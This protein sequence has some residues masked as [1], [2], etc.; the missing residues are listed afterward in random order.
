MTLG[1]LLLIGLAIA[2]GVTALRLSWRIVNKLTDER[3]S[4]DD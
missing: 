1:S 3:P 4:D 2:V